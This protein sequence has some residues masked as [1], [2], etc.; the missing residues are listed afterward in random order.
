[1]N[2]LLLVFQADLKLELLQSNHIIIKG[3]HYVIYR[4]FWSK[5]ENKKCLKLKGLSSDIKQKELAI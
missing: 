5:S 1:M 3:G 2:V 4:A